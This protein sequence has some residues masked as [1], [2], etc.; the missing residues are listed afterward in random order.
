MSANS[1]HWLGDLLQVLIRS[2]ARCEESTI[3]RRNCT[4]QSPAVG[5]AVPASLL[6]CRSEGPPGSRRAPGA[7]TPARRQ[8]RARLGTASSRASSCAELVE[9]LEL[10]RR[11]D[12]ARFFREAAAST[13]HAA[14]RQQV[15]AMVDARTL[16]RARPPLQ[17]FVR[18]PASRR[19]PPPRSTSR[20]KNVAAALER[21]R[22]LLSGPPPVVR[23]CAGRRRQPAACGLLPASVQ[24]AG[25]FQQNAHRVAQPA[26]HSGRQHFGL[27][28]LQQAAAEHQQVARPGCRCPPSR[29]SAG[30][31]GLSERVS[32]QL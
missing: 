32:Y 31:S 25:H 14:N 19:S 17:F 8:P 28:Q 7:T 30:S 27:D 1:W 4:N 26:K 3:A 22:P 6:V 11:T 24:P 23:S 18:A 5:G 21:E 15:V 13:A 2:A 12:R 9:P 16:E 10:L 20:C 29:R